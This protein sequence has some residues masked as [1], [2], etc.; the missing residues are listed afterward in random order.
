M[1]QVRH[2]WP[3]KLAGRIAI[4]AAV[5]LSNAPLVASA[6]ESSPIHQE[7]LQVYN[8]RPHLLNPQQ[9]RQKSIVLDRFWDKAKA[10]PAVYLPGLRQELTNFS[11]PPFFLFDGGRLLL[12]LSDT[13]AD[14][15]IALAA[16][17]HCDLRDVQSRDYFYQ[18]HRVAALG[19]DTTDAA[20]HILQDPRF[21]VF[22]PQHSL[23]LG[24]DYSLVYLLLPA[25]PNLWLQAAAGRLKTERDETAQKSLLLLLWYAQTDATDRIL[26]EFA[27]DPGKPAA[28]RRYA[29]EL[30][31]R[32]DRISS[33]PGLGSSTGD[34]ESLRQKRRALLRAVSDEALIEL[35]S[36]TAELIARRFGLVK[37]GGAELAIQSGAPGGAKAGGTPA[38]ASNYPHEITLPPASGSASDESR[39]SRLQPGAPCT[40]TPAPTTGAQG[41]RLPKVEGK[42]IYFVPLGEFPASRIQGLIGHY[43]EKLSLDVQ[44]LPAVAIP[45][46]AMDRERGQLV[47]EPL[48][49]GLRRA[50]P[51]LTADPNAIL[52]GFTSFDMYP[53]SMDWKF[54][55]G[56]RSGTERVA[57]V[58]TARLDLHYPGEPCDPALSGT[59]LRKVVTKDIGILYYGLSQNDDSA[60][61]LYGRLLGIEELDAVREEF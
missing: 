42:R 20:L 57:V 8:F 9:I 40:P 43:H 13:P 54:A 37:P 28:A 53:R 26:A 12:A 23:L 18:V 31:H 50:L 3:L 56:W 16:F 2:F 36:T 22:I 38:P 24:Q 46:G 30:L 60:S 59:R 29:T 10:Q 5:L 19:Q 48:L 1:T 34:E 6:A 41:V 52:I 17:A 7:I 58:S 45:P 14:R 4:A 55:F 25:D 21:Q 11:D 49:A 27:A 44:A 33:F 39:L 51:A 35:D 47:A 61:V 15:T 32:K